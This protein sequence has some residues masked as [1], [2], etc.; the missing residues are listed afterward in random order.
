MNRAFRLIEIHRSHDIWRDAGVLVPRFR[1]SVYLDCE[2]HRNGHLFQ[3]MGE[4]DCFCRTPAVPIDDDHSLLFLEG[5]E[6]AV[7]VGI[8]EEDN[9]V[10]RFSTMV[11]SEYF[12]MDGW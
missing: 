4:F 6:D 5:R 3:L 12:R 9:L 7:V 1:K 11:I 10:Q 8:E 2:R